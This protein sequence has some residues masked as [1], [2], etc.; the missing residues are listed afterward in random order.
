M[1]A[2][3]AAC[4]LIFLPRSTAF[5]AQLDQTEDRIKKDVKDDAQRD[6]A[7]HIVVA[8]KSV[9]RRVRINAR[10]KWE[11]WP[12]CC[13]SAR[14]A[15]RRSLAAARPLEGVESA[16]SQRIL[17]LRF[18]LVSVLTEAEWALVFPLP[19]AVASEKKAG[20]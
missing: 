2:V 15:R 14:P 4:V 7:L 12:R 6:K 10:S 11:T 3:I 13:K 1:A 19:G 20:E 9:R 5:Y 16:A 17:D 8:M 18:E